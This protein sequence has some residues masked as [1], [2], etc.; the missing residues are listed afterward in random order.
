MMI[1]SEKKKVMRHVWVHCPG[2]NNFKP[3]VRCRQCEQHK[4]L[5]VVKNGVVVDCEM[6]D[7]LKKKAKGERNGL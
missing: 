1:L 4:A 3:L 2:T 6:D 5:I 7:E